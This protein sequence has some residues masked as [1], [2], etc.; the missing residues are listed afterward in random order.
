MILASH[1]SLT[2]C[3]PQWYFKPLAWIGRCQDKT[4]EKQYE[5]GEYYA[6]RLFGMF[7]LCY[8][9]RHNYKEEKYE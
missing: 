1:N 8:G 3:K 4:I 6:I 7:D 5:L 9:L 2:Y